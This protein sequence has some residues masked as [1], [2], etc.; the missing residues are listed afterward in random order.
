MENLI[1]NKK[2][3]KRKV[4]VRVYMDREK[5]DNL[6]KQIKSLGLDITIEDVMMG[7]L[8][9]KVEATTCLNVQIKRELFDKYKTIVSELEGY[10]IN[11]RELNASVVVHVGFGKL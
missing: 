3:N 10:E 1:I 9:K 11:G 5:V 2:S 6:R 8:K 7:G 4:P